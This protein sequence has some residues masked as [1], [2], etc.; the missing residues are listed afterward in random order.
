MDPS[1]EFVLVVRYGSGSYCISSDALLYVT[2]IS[3]MSGLL[4]MFGSPDVVFLRSFKKLEGF[5]LLV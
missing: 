2:S 1:P 3:R 5:V 4:S